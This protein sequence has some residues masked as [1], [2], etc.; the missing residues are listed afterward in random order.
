MVFNTENE[1]VHHLPLAA[2]GG[3]FVGEGETPRYDG[4]GS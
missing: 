2:T 3:Q 4:T 1:A